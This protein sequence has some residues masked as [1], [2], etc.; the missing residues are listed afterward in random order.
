MSYTK[1]TQEQAEARKEGWTN[2][3]GAM[4]IFGK[5]KSGSKGEFFGYSTSI[6]KKKEDG[7]FD[8]FFLNVRFLKDNDPEKEGAFDVEI[9]KAFLTVDSWQDKTYPAIVIQDFDFI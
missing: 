8:N 7:S 5:K 1:K 3:S 6:G 2:I 4:K 9:H